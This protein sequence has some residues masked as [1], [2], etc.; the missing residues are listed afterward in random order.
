MGRAIRIAFYSIVVIAI[1]YGVIYLIWTGANDRQG[2]NVGMILSFTL[3]GIA[4]VGILYASISNI[5]HNPRSGLSVLIG[6]VLFGLMILIGYSL[7]GGEVLDV[8]LDKGVTSASASKWVDSGL[9]LMY[10]LGAIA[11]IAVI[12]SEITTAIKK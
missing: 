10:G 1:L 7:S 8:Y 2:V 4:A 9:F 5:F 3:L 12:A 6:I 11:F